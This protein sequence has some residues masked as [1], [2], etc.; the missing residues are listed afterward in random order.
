MRTLYR[1]TA[2]RE[3]LESS[4]KVRDRIGGVNF[5]TELYAGLPGVV[6]AQSE[7]RSM[8]WGFPPAL[9]SVSR[10]RLWHRFEVVI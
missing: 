9:K 3:L 1:Y 2:N 10:R 4:F 8:I 7:L 6:V 5:G